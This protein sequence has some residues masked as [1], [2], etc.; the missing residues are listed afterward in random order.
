MAIEY[1]PEDVARI[2]AAV[3]DQIRRFGFA[4]TD[5]TDALRDAK[6]GVRGFTSEVR[7][8]SR[9]LKD[10]LSKFTGGLIKGDEGLKVF[11]DALEAAKNSSTLLGRA[12]D[13]ATKGNPGIKV[14]LGALG[15]ILKVFPE[16][17]TQTD[18]LYKAFTDLSRAGA[19]G[20]DGMDEV[21]NTLQNFGYSVDAAG[22]QKLQGIISD[23]GQ[24]L[25]FLKGNMME[26]VKVMGEM[27]ADFQ[28]GPA[29]KGLLRMG[30]RIEDIN[31]HLTSYITMQARLGTLTVRQG[32][33]AA[34]TNRKLRES[35]AAY[36]KEQDALTKLTGV[37]REQAEAAKEQ[38]LLDEAYRSKLAILAIEKQEALDKGDEEAAKAI[39]NRIDQANDTV[40]ALAKNPEEM[41]KYM[42][43]FSEYIGDE[44]ASAMQAWGTGVKEKIES[45]AKYTDVIGE[46]GQRNK[47]FLD[48]GM[49]MLGTQKA[50][51]DWIGN[52]SQM[53]NV[54]ALAN[55]PEKIKAIRDAQEKAE[56]EK[57]N[58]LTK[59]YTDL[60]AA[61]VR[62]RQSFEAVVHSFSEAATNVAYRITGTFEQAMKG[63]AN[64]IRDFIKEQLKDT[65]INIPMEVKTQPAASG[66]R[67]ER[68]PFPNP[69]P[70]AKAIGG[71]VL[72]G[73]PYFV[74]E[75]GT[76][77]FV[78]QVPGS[79]VPNDIVKMMKTFS[80]NPEF[81][82]KITNAIKSMG[83]VFEGNQARPSLHA[84]LKYGGLANKTAIAA[85]GALPEVNNPFFSGGTL[86]VEMRG[87]TELLSKQNDLL[88]AQADRFDSLL[89]K[90]D[91]LNSTST[92]IMQYSQ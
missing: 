8:S 82:Q 89:A 39:Q 85:E 69:P 61:Q 86:P 1:T 20:A 23:F 31:A 41:K 51:G 42:A 74:G 54:T 92:R 32:E 80:G 78:P 11:A 65:K 6:I 83:S 14:F 9:A 49:L 10:N 40:A 70:E 28:R 77:L 52:V 33:D 63:A 24:Q 16:V 66:P 30:M 56:S 29:A 91:T 27:A 19:V 76:E 18:S 4:T 12:M 43:V 73:N 21:F 75:R 7:A 68:Q 58:A 17:L 71:P 34:T 87:V 62:M 90:M 47:E 46:I 15:Q 25:I 67:G 53:L 59:N 37:S 48:K 45:G 57:A 2:D 44:Y 50:L 35:A 38:A 3:Q 60:V 72:A 55:A 5:M 26:S 13:V 64:S 88:A 36:M 84:E 79:I 81:S 22:A